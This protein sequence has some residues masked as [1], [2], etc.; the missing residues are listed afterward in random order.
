MR[1]IG[2][3][4]LLII[5]LTGSALGQSPPPIDRLP[6]DTVFFFAWHGSAA[7]EKGRATSALL[8][9]WDDPEMVAAR[10][11]LMERAARESTSAEAAGD[12]ERMQALWDLASNPFVIGFANSPDWKFLSAPAGADGK[13][14]P[15][16][17]FLIYDRTGKADQL[18]RV[19]ALLA[20]KSAEKP[21]VTTFSFSGVTVRKETSSKR[22]DFSAEFDNCIV[23]SDSQEV[24]EKLI[25][26]LKGPAPVDSFTFSHAY[27]AAAAERTP[28]AF[29]ELF[30]RIPDLSK[31]AVPPAQGMNFAAMLKALHL[32]RVQAISASASLAGQ[33]ARMRGAVLG[34]TAPGSIFDLFAT[35]NGEFRT[36]AAAPSGSAYS[37]MKLD[38]FTFYQTLRTA[39]RAGLAPE[40]AS[41]FEM[42]EGMMGTQLGM[43]IR[44]ALQ[45][46]AG[47]V[48]TIQ[49]D[50]EGNG[51]AGA[52]AMLDPLRNLY[53]LSTDRPEEAL[54][55]IRLALASSIT[56]ESVEGNTTVLAVTSSYRDEKSGAQ[57]KRF[58]YV[59]VTPKM[60]ILAPRKA[61]LREAV[62]RV[63]AQQ[64]PAAG[65]LASDST[66]LQARNRLPHPLTALSYSDFSRIP[67]Q[68]AL[69]AVLKQAGEKDKLT[70]REQDALRAVFRVLPR[71]LHTAFGGYWK[72]RN[73]IFMESYIE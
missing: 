70:P 34:N 57:R 28:D 2:R 46:I 1:I 6:L 44:E 65:G 39:I 9:L 25:T 3:A 66:F 15:T 71:Y 73:G 36:L 24:I 29:F 55:L 64:G 35:G 19:G 61:Q 10:Q 5:V 41:Q 69:E 52:A 49:L 31:V 63:T 54:K 23:V 22:A 16:G 59:G 4:V 37:V 72:D 32:E 8:R 67:W 45:L 62:A 30:A 17:F 47:E 56:S 18:A 21:V 13:R 7:I 53:V 14:T 68:A 20:E 60:I 33:G 12:K 38:L 42:M 58:N 48:A 26:R 11:V 27:Q 43:G 40:Q 51:R 50:S